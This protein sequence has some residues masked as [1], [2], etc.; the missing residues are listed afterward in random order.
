[1]GYSLYGLIAVICCSMIYG[2]QKPKQYKKLVT[3]ILEHHHSVY[4]VQVVKRLDLLDFLTVIDI[5]SV[6]TESD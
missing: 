4:N 5:T 1:M 6:M 2:H 3:T